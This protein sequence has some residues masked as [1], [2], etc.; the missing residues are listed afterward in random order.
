MNGA[1]E[2]E[3]ERE[4]GERVGL[5][6]GVKTEKSRSFCNDFNRGQIET[7]CRTGKER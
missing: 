3:N 1:R 6:R 4:R 5:E 7:P 2:R